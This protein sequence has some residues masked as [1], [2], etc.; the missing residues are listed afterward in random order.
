M[1]IYLHINDMIINILLLVQLYLHHLFIF[2]QINH[3]HK[4]HLLLL[5]L[6]TLIK[7]VVIPLNLK[8]LNLKLIFKINYILYAFE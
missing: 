8:Y 3:I 6:L 5:L 1:Q 4:I 2:F 7:K